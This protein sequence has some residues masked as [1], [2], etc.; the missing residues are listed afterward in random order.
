MDLPRMIV[1]DLDDT[2]L[3]SDKTVTK[4]TADILWKIKARDVAV[5][6][7]TARSPRQAPQFLE[8]LP[9]DAI[10]YFNGAK[11]YC[12]GELVASHLIDCGEALSLITNVL[13]RNPGMAITANSS[14]ACYFSQ[15][16]PTVDGK[17]N[18]LTDFSGIDVSGFDRILFWTGS[19]EAIVPYLSEN[20]YCFATA[21]TNVVVTHKLA[22]KDFALAHILNK[23][24]I[25]SEAVL[26]FGDD[27]NDIDLFRA[28]GTGV[29]VGNAIDGLKRIATHITA[30]NDHDGVAVFLEKNL[31]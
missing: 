14:P 21:H 4:Y 16:H 17:Y 9:C 6:Y 24:N 2:L 12:N 10:A 23:L 25:K 15:P 8:G 18:L 3:T 29:A 30:S 22:R 31:L 28:S 27:A 19:V 11:V 7:I 26:S 20:M 1:M 13:A 5:A